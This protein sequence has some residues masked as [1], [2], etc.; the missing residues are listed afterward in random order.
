MDWK[1]DPGQ[2]P[3]HGLRIQK[4]GRKK[5]SGIQVYKQMLLLCHRWEQYNRMLNNETC[6]DQLE[7]NKL[8][9]FT[10]DLTEVEPQD[11][12]IVQLLKTPIPKEM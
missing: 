2:F 6:S 7:I 12:V 10:N 1:D 9:V 8:G 11:S 4:F 3:R 5:F